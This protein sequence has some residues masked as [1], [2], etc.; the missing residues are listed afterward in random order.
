M[1]SKVERHHLRLVAEVIFIQQEDGYYGDGISVKIREMGNP[2]D[3]NPDNFYKLR[4]REE[5]LRRRDEFE[6]QL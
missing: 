5:S 3:S 6:S 2:N 1:V 4:L